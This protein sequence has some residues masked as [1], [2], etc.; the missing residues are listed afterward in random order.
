MSNETL[1]VRVGLI[2]DT[3]FMQV[4]EMP[5]R[6]RGDFEFD[7]SVGIC[8][9]S[10]GDCPILAEDECYLWGRDSGH[11]NDVVACSVGDDE[12]RGF[13]A[14]LQQALT[15]AKLEMAHQTMTISAPCGPYLYFDESM[16]I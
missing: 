8:V 2:D 5:E 13:Y 12:G 16:V 15:E 4:Q 14:R 1:R 3:V 9:R 11:D 6:F 10:T 7:S